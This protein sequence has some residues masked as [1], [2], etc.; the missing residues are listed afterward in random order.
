MAKTIF[1]QE[2]I[3]NYLPEPVHSKKPKNTPKFRPVVT[4]KDKP[5]KNAM[6]T[7]GPAKVEAPSPEKYLKKHS[8]VPET[9]ERCHRM[10][11]I[12]KPAVPLRSEHPPEGLCTKRSIIKPTTTRQQ[13]ASV[14]TNRGHKALLEHSGLIPKYSKKKGY[15]QVPQ[16]LRHRSEEA[17]R[18]VD[19]YE[20]QEEER[21][22]LRQ[23]SDE[24]R[25]A[26]LENLKSTLAELN[27]KYQRLPVVVDT[28]MRKTR[29]EQLEAEM[30]QLESDVVLFERF[31][32]IYIAD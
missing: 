17:Q 3:Y 20:F 10:C 7:M 5:L 2:S 13:V 22:A 26:N 32:T 11:T 18:A 12:K 14:D 6:K 28:P 23:L 30:K 1:P 9:K 24:E 19:D 27:D 15:G 16:Y 8:K 4:L 21:S 29:K 25:Q 31:K